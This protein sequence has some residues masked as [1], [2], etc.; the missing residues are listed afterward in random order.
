M[1]ASADKSFTVN[2]IARGCSQRSECGHILTF[3]RSQ[4]WIERCCAMTSG[5]ALK[6]CCRARP[7]I[8]AVQRRTTVC[9]SRRSSGFCA[10]AAHGV[11]CPESLG[12]GTAHTC[13]LPVGVTA[14]FGS[15]WPTCWVA[16]LTWNTC[17]SIPPSSA[18]TSIQ[19]DIMPSTMPMAN[20]TA[21]VHT[22]TIR[23]T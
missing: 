14:A 4:E 3:R 20:A 17:S 2:G 21:A 15:G 13:A 11:T 7:A 18:P 9:S 23:D 12:N 22:P 19:P 10:Q 1:Q 8:Q 6:S 16:M 5:H